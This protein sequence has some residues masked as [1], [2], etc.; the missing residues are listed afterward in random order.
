M[1]GS[2]RMGSGVLAS[3][4]ITVLYCSSSTVLHSTVAAD[5]GPLMEMAVEVPLRFRERAETTSVCSGGQHQDGFAQ[6]VHTP[7]GAPQHEGAQQAL[8]ELSGCAC[9]RAGKGSAPASATCGGGKKKGGRRD[10]KKRGGER[11][12]IFRLSGTVLL[13]D[14][15]CTTR[16]CCHTI[17]L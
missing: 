9:R 1:G 11:K 14:T 3:W 16:M 10:G 17:Q 8:E 2:T 13:Y 5:L 7:L 15:T 12:T 4:H 6:A